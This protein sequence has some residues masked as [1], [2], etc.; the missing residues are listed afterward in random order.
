MLA[1]ITKNPIWNINEKESMALAVALL[2]VMA[3][4]QININP[5][6]LSYLKLIGAVV[7][8]HGSRVMVIQ[9]AQKKAKQDEKERT[10][11]MPS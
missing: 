10:V 9:M 3:H 8:V 2:D 4:H 6:T 7:A 5:A 11:D 1:L